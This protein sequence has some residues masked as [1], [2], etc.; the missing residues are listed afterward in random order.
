[1][2]P[3]GVRVCVFL[4]CFICTL[5]YSISC[6]FNYAY[7]MHACLLRAFYFTLFSVA[8][9]WPLTTLCRCRFRSL[10]AEM[11]L[12]ASCLFILLD[13][14]QAWNSVPFSLRSTRYATV[15]DVRK[16]SASVTTTD[17]IMEASSWPASDAALQSLDGRYWC[18]VIWCA[19][20]ST[21]IFSAR[22]TAVI[23][24]SFRFIIYASVPLA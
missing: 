22:L 9:F 16:S 19:V 21:V 10:M 23:C 8:N 1:V 20:N 2:S 4:H 11:S 18:D 17:W 14:P 3:L 6:K 15:H 24:G 7:L 5:L 12:A 13:F